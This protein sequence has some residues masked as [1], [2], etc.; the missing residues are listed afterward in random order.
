MKFARFAKS[1]KKATAIALMAAL[2]VPALPLGV[3]TV[4]AATSVPL[5]SVEDF[6]TFPETLGYSLHP[7]GEYF[8]F[9]APVDGVIN[10]FTRHIETGEV[11]QLTFAEEQHILGLFFKGSTTLFMQDGFG[12]ENFHIFRM[13]EDGTST[14]L[15]PFPGVMASPA[16]LLENTDVEDEILIMMNREDLTSFNTYRLNIFT[17]EIT[18]V[19]EGTSGGIMTDNDGVIR[20]IANLIDGTMYFMHRYTD[21]DD[22]ELVTTVG[23]R[24]NFGYFFFDPTNT[25]VYGVSNIGRDTAA[26]V[27]INPATAEVLEVI[28]EVEN[29]DVMGPIQGR[30]PGTLS[31]V[32]YVDDFTNWVFF[33]PEREA[34]QNQLAAHFPEG[35]NININ[36]FSENWDRAIVG[37][38]SDICRG[39]QYFFNVE[40]DTLELMLDTNFAPTEHMAPM[41]PITYEARDGLTIQGYLTLPVG[42][43]PVDLPVVVIVHGGPWARDFWGFNPE[44]QFL[45]NRGYAV[46][47][48]NFRGSTGF[49]RA[50]LDAGD[51]EWGL[52]MQDDVTDG[53][54]W[55]IEQG[56]ADPDRIGI[57]GGSYGGYSALAGV[58]FTPDLF[59]A[60]IAYVPVSSIFTLLDSLPAHWE[61]QRAMFYSRVGHPVYDYELLRAASPVYH[62]ENIT[63]PLFIAHG[64]NDV[65][66][67]LP[68]SVNIVQALNNHGVDVEF[69]VRW[70]EG[71]GFTGEQN[72]LQFYAT[73]EAFFAEHLGGRTG[74]TMDEIRTRGYT[75]TLED[76]LAI[77]EQAAGT[78]IAETAEEDTEADAEEDTEADDE[79]AA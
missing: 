17:G 55:L 15:T 43:E 25:Y 53:V 19:L 33:C 74:T 58:A 57:Y 20:V 65:R 18:L 73:M 8:V 36:S 62:V 72:R 26:A 22:F 47:Q 34:I 54:L 23:Y 68:E 16:N 59:A 12:D 4:Q 21:D 2:A 31:A 49:G 50:F 7:N 3:A 76:V 78:D 13:N 64:A 5:Y 63:T 14:N 24:D 40:E 9:S 10:V 35:T 52:A 60:S 46:L 51:G 29:F 66:T 69:M 42:V 77:M 45:A 27:R 6:F 79:Y 32:V 37:T 1:F 70:D 38:F 48:P 75:D 44:V 67:T 56:I 41:M 11:T 39:R 28:F 71:H 30:L 61:G